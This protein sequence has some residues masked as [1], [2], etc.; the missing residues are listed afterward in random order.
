LVPFHEAAE[1]IAFSTFGT[2]NKLIEK[3]LSHEAS[4]I[5]HLSHTILL[6]GAIVVRRRRTEVK[7]VERAAASQ[8]DGE[9]V[10]LAGGRLA[11][12]PYFNRIDRAG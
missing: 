2:L 3:V 1:S 6:P 8:V 9:S 12:L 10:H 11:N 7:S 4:W 5:D